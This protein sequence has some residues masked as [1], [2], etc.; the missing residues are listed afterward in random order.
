MDGLG[1]FEIQKS[2]S[3]EANRHRI[4]Q[5]GEGA[6][7]SGSFFFFSHDDKFIIKTMSA[8]ERD[9]MLGMLDDYIQYI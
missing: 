8:G 2:L 6:G 5:A 7:A 4:F 3:V 9:K 1:S